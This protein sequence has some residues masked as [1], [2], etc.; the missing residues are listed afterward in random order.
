M[1][2]TFVHLYSLELNINNQNFNRYRCPKFLS[3]EKKPAE[4]PCFSFDWYS[5]HGPIK[6]WGLREKVLKG[7]GKVYKAWENID[8]WFL[9]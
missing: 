2:E 8:T 4:I 1:V 5:V 7:V 6:G 3:L 9:L